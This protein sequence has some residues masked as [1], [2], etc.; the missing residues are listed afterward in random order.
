MRCPDKL[1]RARAAM[2]NSSIIGH[3]F[4]TLGNIMTKK[5]LHQRPYLIYNADETGMSLDAKKSRVIVPT[6]SKRAPSPFDVTVFST[7]KAQ[8][9]TTLETLQA[10]DT[11]FQAKKRNFPAIFSTVQDS[12]FTPNNIKAGFRKTGIYPYNPDA[13]EGVWKGMST[14]SEETAHSE[15]N[16][17][18]KECSENA[19]TS[20]PSEPTVISTTEKVD[21]TAACCVTCG[22]AT[23]NPISETLVPKRLQVIL[24][25]LENTT[26]PQTKRKKLTARVMTHQDIIDE[27]KKKEED[28]K[29]KKANAEER[30]KKAMLNRMQKKAKAKAVAERRKERDERKREMEANKQAGGKRKDK[31][32]KSNAGESREKESFNRMHTEARADVVRRKERKGRK[33]PAETVEQNDDQKSDQGDVVPAESKRRRMK[34]RLDCYEYDC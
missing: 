21:S 25:P 29:L 3:H 14:K 2:S 26:T 12:S 6:S 24:R 7:L 13:V 16:E 4:K 5:K 18:D 11:K 19:S 8:W 1:Y 9:A 20:Q 15:R 22:H 33:M 30:K 10:A 23:V 31:R 27:L 17:E 32:M 28:E 34:K